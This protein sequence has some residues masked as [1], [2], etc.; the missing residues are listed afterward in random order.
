VCIT[1]DPVPAI[2]GDDIAY[3]C[4][5][6]HLH[7]VQAASC[8]PST[9]AQD[10]D[11]DVQIQIVDAIDVVHMLHDKEIYCTV[12]QSSSAGQSCTQHQKCTQKQE[13]NFTWHYALTC[14]NTRHSS[15]NIRV[16]SPDPCASS[17]V[18]ALAQP[19]AGKTQHVVAPWT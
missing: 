3:V 1:A 18:R 14:Q 5:F 19:Y 15:S 9:S 13:H 10:P 16:S 6:I 8:A 4:F 17:K 11:S 2:K 12:R 7:E